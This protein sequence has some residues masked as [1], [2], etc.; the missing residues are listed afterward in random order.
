M[1]ALRTL[2]DGKL[3]PSIERLEPVVRGMEYSAKILLQKPHVVPTV[4]NGLHD[5]IRE[6]LFLVSQ[7]QEVA[8][9]ERKGRQVPTRVAAAQQLPLLL[10]SL[11]KNAGKFAA[12]D[13]SHD[14]VFD[15]GRNLN[16]IRTLTRALTI[17]DAELKIPAVSN[18][19]QR[20]RL[21]KLTEEFDLIWASAGKALVNLQAYVTAHHAI[22]HLQKAS[23]ELVSGALRVCYAPGIRV[24][25]RS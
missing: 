22:S 20:A 12:A 1:L 6:S 11:S 5:V 10:D 18:A 21:L 24:E 7:A 15:F 17:G 4:Q 8:A 25:P 19:Q 13:M 3:P 9:N 14:A 16:D 2:V 23:S